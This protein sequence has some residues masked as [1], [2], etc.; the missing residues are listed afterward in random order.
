LTR[1]VSK[2]II[3]PALWLKRITLSNHN[4]DQVAD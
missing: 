1:Q 4:R 2:L 3:G